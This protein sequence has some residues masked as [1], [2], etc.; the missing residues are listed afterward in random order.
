MSDLLLLGEWDGRDLVVIDMEEVEDDGSPEAQ[1]VIDEIVAEFA[2]KH[3]STWAYSFCTL[4]LEEALKLAYEQEFP[5]GDG[6]LYDTIEGD[7][8][9]DFG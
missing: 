6:L 1:A 8:L 9:G 2:K 5:T 3:E 4:K 7:V